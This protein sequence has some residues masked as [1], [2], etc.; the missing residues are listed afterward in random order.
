MSTTPTRDEASWWLKLPMAYV[1]LTGVLVGLN[2]MAAA[3]Y[4]DGVAD[5]VGD[6][7]HWIM[8]VG[9]ILMIGLSVYARDRIKGYVSIGLTIMFF[10]VWTCS[11][12]SDSDIAHTAHAVWWPPVDT[13]YALLGIAVSR[14]LWAK[15][16]IP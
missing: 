13:G 7:L 3:T 14:K 9:V 8:A 16:T 2:R 11:T 5:S 4:P 6:V 10:W 12:F 1:L 15:W